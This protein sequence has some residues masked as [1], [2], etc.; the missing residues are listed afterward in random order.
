MNKRFVFVPIVGMLA[1]PSV[2]RSV[3][4]ALYETIHQYHPIGGFVLMV[5]LDILWM[6][7]ALVVVLLISRVIRRVLKRAS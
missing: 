1:L 3:F 5:L 2:F 4:G 6:W 7:V